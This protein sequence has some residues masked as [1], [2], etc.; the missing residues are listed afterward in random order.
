MMV[1]SILEDMGDGIFPQWDIMLDLSIKSHLDIFIT[2][3]N[4]N[5]TDIMEIIKYNI[6]C[7]LSTFYEY[8][9]INMIFNLYTQ[10]YKELYIATLTKLFLSDMVDFYIIDEP[11]Q[12]TLSKMKS[13]LLNFITN[14]KI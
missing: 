2:H 6:V 11:T 13:L 4:I 1:F 5:K 3:E 8:S 14:I 10:D 9:E 7:E 12:P